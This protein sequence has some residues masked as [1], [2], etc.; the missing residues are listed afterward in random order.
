MPNTHPDP[1]A[2][3]KHR[4]RLAYA[5]F[6]VLVGIGVAAL[7]IPVDRLD[8]ATPLLSTLA[9]VFGSVI[10]VYVGAATYAGVARFK[11]EQP[12]QRRSWG[13]DDRWD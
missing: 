12:Q 10:L 2:W 9:A 11:A 5:S 1:S 7:V 6:G 3:W 8:A 13:G 4:R